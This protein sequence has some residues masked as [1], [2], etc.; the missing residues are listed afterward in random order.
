MPVPSPRNKILPARGDY[1][2]LLANVASI[3]DGEIC[4]A[5]DQDQYYQNEGG[6]LVAVGATKVQGALADSAV[7]P[8]D[9]VS[10]LT[11]DAAY[12]TS[13]GA[14]VQSVAG[15]TGVVVLDA[16]DVDDTSTAHKFVTAA[17][18][19]ALGTLSSDLAAK[20]DL[21]G[22]V[23]P[24]SQLPALAITEYLGIAADQTAMLALTGQRGDWAIRTDT[25]TTWVI[26]TDGGSQLSDWTELA[27]PADAVSSVNGYQGTVVL[28]AA[29]VGAATAA[30]GTLAD[31]ALQ[32][33]DQYW[34]R[35]GTDLSPANAGDSVDIGPG[36]ISLNADGTASFKAGGDGVNIDSSGRLG[37]GTSAPAIPLDVHG[38]DTQTAYGLGDV[39][40]QLRVFNDTTAFGSSPRAGIVFST[41]YRTSPDVPLDGAAIY[42][43][44]EDAADTIKDF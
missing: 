11:N 26:T 5:I 38:A 1:S 28:S 31:S 2:D 43:G 30:Q 39:K 33:A 3:L 8:G 13:A 40:G 37:I 22:G 21:V 12:I 42:G 10:T 18:V 23:V 36:N 20:A 34:S 16:D 6:T 9:N 27:T 32:P 44:K 14:P 17:D 41:K 24:N 35:T 7:Q 25:S 15:K 19:T 4:Y 29:D